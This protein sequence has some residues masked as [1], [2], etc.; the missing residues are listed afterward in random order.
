V[1]LVAVAAVGSVGFYAVAKGNP[2]SAVGDKWQEFKKG[3]DPTFH[4]NRLT[5][6]FT[7]YR[8]DYWRV[9]WR[10]F[11]QAPILGVGADN[12]AHDYLRLGKSKETPAYP[13]STPLRP[14]SETGLV[15]G[16]LFYAAMLAAL[17]AALSGL[18]GARLGGVAAGTGLVMLGYW[19]VHGS[20]DFLWEFPVLGGVA[21]LGLGIAIAVG[22]QRDSQAPSG[23]P[24]LAGRRAL[25]PA[26]AAALVLAVG[27]VLPWFAGRDLKGAREI[28]G[29]DP[30]GALSRLD[31]SARL[32]PL[33]PLAQRTAGLIRVRQNDLG[34]ARREFAASLE[35]DRRD[36]FSLLMLAAIASDQ[37]QPGRAKA[38]MRGARQL[39]PRW[40]ILRAQQSRIEKGKR[41]DAR[42]LE[43][44]FR[45]D[46]QVRIGPD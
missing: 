26:I 11:Q 1:I 42:G 31:R 20:V 15:G 40:T 41:I 7:T 37:G 19:L 44:A 10:E 4:G 5:A 28:A 18:R 36:P 32:N 30:S 34:G 35:R 39:A 8:Y 29:S 27:L 38:L 2:V 6:A 46:I 13:H 45:N 3:G 23:L 9:A 22:S 21:L 14:L 12:F 25:V 43:N 16:L 24:L 17:A 33:S